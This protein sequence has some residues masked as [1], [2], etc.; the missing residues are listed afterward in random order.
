[1]T[2]LAIVLHDDQRQL[3]LIES[4]L[5]EQGYAVRSVRGAYDVLTEELPDEV[6]LIVVGLTAVDERDLELVALL[7]ERQPAAQIVLLFPASLRDRAARA[8]A[9][10]ADSYLPEP[11]YP[12]ELAS[13]AERATARE[14]LRG[15]SASRAAAPHDSAVEDADYDEEAD[16]L[17]D[18]LAQLAAGIAHSLRNPLQILEL[19]VA[20][21]ELGDPLDAEKAQRELRRIAD[22]ASS[23][24][25]FTVGREAE[26]RPVDL[27]A[28]VRQ[29]F[30]GRGPVDGLR[31]QLSLASQAPFVLAQPES[32]QTALDVVRERAERVTPASG[33][34]R[35]STRMRTVEG[36]PAVELEIVDDGPALDPDR[37]QQLFD[38]FPAP[39]APQETT[40]IELAAFAGIVRN[41]GGTT[42]AER[43][44]DRGT[45]IRVILPVH[46]AGTEH[47]FAEGR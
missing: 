39:D 3:A 45:R 20:S 35:V 15:T 31:P 17:A 36:Q 6:T 13:L 47:P 25:R 37:L 11:F 34:V 43:A 23:L 2:S 27:N 42:T 38:P 19:L 10:G 26:P 29:T 4:L 22:V 44:G 21:V 8:L 1:M 24:T 41:H 7:R 12:G 16:E 14:Q 33:V 46:Q 30:L 5:T 40:W 18:H 9:Q 28:L 32:L